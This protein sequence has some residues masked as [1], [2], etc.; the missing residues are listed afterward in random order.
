MI[1]HSE[2]AIWSE[3]LQRTLI[4]SPTCS[5]EIYH[6]TVEE[7]PKTDLLYKA[8]MERLHF[9]FQM[10]CLQKWGCHEA[11]REKFMHFRIGLCSEAI[12]DDVSCL[13]FVTM[14]Y[15]FLNNLNKFGSMLHVAVGTTQYLETDGTL[16]NSY[17][18]HTAMILIHSTA[19]GCTKHM[20]CLRFNDAHP[21]FLSPTALYAISR[22][23][24]SSMKKTYAFCNGPLE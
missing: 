23:S 10:R 12:L 13:W 6:F 19:E 3:A 24:C 14:P 7:Q 4:P 15:F 11:M 22:L 1:M 17:T 16:R 8:N 20:S 9:F 21:Q 18:S 2:M 5:H